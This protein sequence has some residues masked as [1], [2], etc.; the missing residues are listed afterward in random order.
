LRNTDEK[1]G[2]G[3]VMEALRAIAS[4]LLRA[5]I[6]RL[7]LAAS[8]IEEQLLRL[9]GVLL[10]LILGGCMLAMAL[11]LGVL[12]LIVLFWDGNRILVISLLLVAFSGSGLL[13]LLWA[14]R[15]LAKRPAL[16]STTLSELRKDK[17][18]LHE[19]H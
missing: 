1:P 5:L 4:N 3:S 9:S 12:L 19:R 2:D 16:L 8:D 14:R 18:A 15:Q 17:D 11:W 10:L 7:E 6:T 13:C